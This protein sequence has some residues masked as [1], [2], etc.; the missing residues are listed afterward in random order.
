MTP[1]AIALQAPPSMGFLRQENWSVL[2]F[3]S[4]RDL[5]DSGIKSASADLA[6]GFFTAQPSGKSLILT[7]EVLILKFVVSRSV[8][9]DSL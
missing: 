8:V 7:L 4:P 6:G 9:S 3:C 2:P 1:L 5:P